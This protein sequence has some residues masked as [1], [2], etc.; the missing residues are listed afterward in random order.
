MPRNKSK[1]AKDLYSDNCK[2]LI[3]EIEDK[4]NR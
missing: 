3:K 1:E 4:T 2:T